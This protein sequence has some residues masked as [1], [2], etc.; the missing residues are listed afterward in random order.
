ML[1]DA[2]FF[3]VLLPLLTSGNFRPFNPL[4]T[5]VVWYTIMAGPFRRMQIL[6]WGIIFLGTNA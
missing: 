6:G 2:S 4:P 3:A 1:V 5:I